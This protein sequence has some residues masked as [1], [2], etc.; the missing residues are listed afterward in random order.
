M[1]R[2]TI[3][4][5]VVLGAL[6]G[7]QTGCGGVVLY[8]VVQ[9]AVEACEIRSN[10]EFCEDDD[11]LPTPRSA[12][13]GVEYTENQTILYIGDTTWIAQGTTDE[14]EAFKEERLTRGDC[15]ASTTRH[16]IFTEDFE[17]FVGTLDEK[18]RTTGPESCGETPFGERVSWQL[19]GQ[20]AESL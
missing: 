11:R 1:I 19:Q 17:T 12:N 13:W 15:T 2:R 14:R 7:L 9:T 18:I 6:A 16:L 3:A 8:T 5:V 20:R 10:G 4:Q